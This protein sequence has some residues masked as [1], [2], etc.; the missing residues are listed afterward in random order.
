MT[1]TFQ[2]GQDPPASAHSSAPPAPATAPVSMINLS[3][4]CADAAVDIGE[5]HGHTRRSW[6]LLQA[7]IFIDRL[8]PLRDRLR[9]WAGAVKA[10]TID[11]TDRQRCAVPG[12]IG[13][14]E[15]EPPPSLG[16]MA[17]ACS[18]AGFALQVSSFAAARARGA[19]LRRAA[20][21]LDRLHPLL[22]LI[23]KHLAPRDRGAVQRSAS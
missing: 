15:R 17:L 7:S 10:D 8:L 16:D 21:F 14:T 23:R 6:A 12:A 18:D 3:Q 19:L 5:R 9:Q 13:R 20:I 2:P 11:R 4:A 22:G 1:G